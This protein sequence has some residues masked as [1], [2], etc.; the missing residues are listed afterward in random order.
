[1]ASYALNP[2][3]HSAFDDLLSDMDKSQHVRYRKAVKARWPDLVTADETARCREL[4][5]ELADRNIERLNAKLEVHEQNADANARRTVDRLGFDQGRDGER[6]RA[7]K[8]KCRSGFFRAMEAYRKH[9]AKKRAEGRER[10]GEYPPLTA[11]DRER[12]PGDAS[13]SAAGIEA[14][15]HVPDGEFVSEN[16][17]NEANFDESV[18]TIQNEE[19][20]DVT[21]ESA[22]DSGLDKPQEQPGRA[23]GKPDRVSDGSFVG[24]D[25]EREALEQSI[26]TTAL[27]DRGAQPNG[28]GMSPR[29]EN[30]QNDTNEAKVDDSMITIQHE[31]PIDVT[32]ESAV[33]SGLDKLQE[34]PGMAKGNEKLMSAIPASPPESA[35]VLRPHVP[36]S[37]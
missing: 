25:G 31:E 24:E 8:L 20:I 36:R 5:I 37:P 15:H 21:A 9:Q 19:P 17:T 4:L 35:E 22:V 6:I 14:S 10:T 3:G 2:V 12:R 7:Y 11:K 13:R 29:G 33:D 16:L 30:R 26:D 27:P 1:M 18:I 34:Q 23:E 32:A 28:D